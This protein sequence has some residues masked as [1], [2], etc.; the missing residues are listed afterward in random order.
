[1]LGIAL[2]LFQ[3]FIL[4]ELLVVDPPRVATSMFFVSPLRLCL[5]G[6]FIDQ[7]TLALFLGHINHI[8]WMKRECLGL[9]TPYYAMLNSDGVMSLLYFRDDTM[10]VINTNI[11]ANSSI[12]FMASRYACQDIAWLCLVFSRYW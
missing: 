3:R 1:V 4:D 11:T 12:N 8:N 9:R 10:E 7:V 5:C 2:N 6:F